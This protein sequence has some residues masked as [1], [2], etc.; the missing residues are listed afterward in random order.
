MNEKKMP[1]GYKKVGVYLPPS[2]HAIIDAA[3]GTQDFPRAM[4][5]IVGALPWIAVTLS[6]AV[7][8]EEYDLFLQQTRANFDAM[9]A[10][11]R[12]TDVRAAFDAAL[13]AAKKTVN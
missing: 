2:V 7:S 4:A 3:G 11:M 9:W 5:C 12:A 10:I 6:E 8:R 1:D 13:A